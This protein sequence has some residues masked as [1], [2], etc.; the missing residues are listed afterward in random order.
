[1]EGIEGSLEALVLSLILFG[2]RAC[3]NW[4][5][6]LSLI[7]TSRLAGVILARKSRGVAISTSSLRLVYAVYACSSS[8]S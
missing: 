2:R 4:S 7:L 8:I 5:L 1:M 3:Q 6:R